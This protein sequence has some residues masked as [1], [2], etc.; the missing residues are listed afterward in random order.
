M[1]E[2]I[3]LRNEKEI[4]LKRPPVE[5]RRDRP[6][7]LYIRTVVPPIPRCDVD[8]LLALKYAEDK[9]QKTRAPA[10]PPPPELKEEEVTSEAE[11]GESV[12]ITQVHY[13]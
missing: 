9:E 6:D 10:S 3:E 2:K 11:T 8:K 12:F 4:A 7:R 1:M 5:I 13:R